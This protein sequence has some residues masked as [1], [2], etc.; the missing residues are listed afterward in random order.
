MSDT[1]DDFSVT[2]H[3]S[4]NRPM[5]LLGGERTLVL[6]LGVIAGVFI[7]SLAAL[8]AAAVGVGMWLVGTW[9]LSRAGDYDPL[10]S[11]TGPRSLKYKRFYPAAS[12]PFAPAREI[13]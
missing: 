8:W 13:K 6:L 9:V 1:D 5:L 3:Q 11:K 7:F 4:L 12:T 10:L 2:I